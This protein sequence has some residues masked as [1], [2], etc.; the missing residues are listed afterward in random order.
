MQSIGVVWKRHELIMA[1]LRQGATKIHLDGYRIVPL[2]DVP[3]GERQEVMLHHLDRFVKTFRGARDNLFI[4]IPRDEAIVRLIPLPAA[5]EENLR[6][7]LGYGIDTYIPGAPEDIYFDCQVVGRL[8]EAGLVQVL[9]VAVRRET[10]DGYLNVLKKIGL[11]PRGIDITTTALLNAIP[12]PAPEP[13]AGRKRRSAVAVLQDLYTEKIARLAGMLLNPAVPR[14]PASGVDILIAGLDDTTYELALVDRGSLCAAEI[15]RCAP[16]A[17][18]PLP[19]L[20]Q[21]ALAGLI[22]LPH[23]PNRAAHPVRMLFAGRSLEDR[24]IERAAALQP[25]ILPVGELPVARSQQAHDADPAVLAVAVGLALKGVGGALIDLNLIPPGLRLRKKRNMRKL[26]AAGCLMLLIAAALGGAAKT[27]VGMRAELAALSQ[28]V[29]ELKKQVRAVE[30]QQEEARKAEQAKAAIDAIRA[31]DVGKVKLLEELTRIIPED[32]FLT[33]FH[34]KADEKKI[35]L[36]GFAV[37]A[38]KLIPLLEESPLFDNVKFTSP[39]TTDKRTGKERF[40]LEMNLTP[41][42]R[43]TP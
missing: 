25:Q 20:H 1:A 9:V 17:P 38:S 16:D 23:D 6:A 15:V 19:E 36:S 35:K 18:T 32:S 40:R 2:R 27:T 42:G 39:I 33:E 11:R 37:S 21:R 8:P 24:D 7:S 12:A 3:D 22:H 26:I 43:G 13:A 31:G 29:S 41:P 4:G 14:H 34:Y 10:V 28:E 5:V 30:A